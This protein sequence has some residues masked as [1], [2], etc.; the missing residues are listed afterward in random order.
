MQNPDTKSVRTGEI[1][2]VQNAEA[3]DAYTLKLNLKRPD[4]A[5]LATL[6]DRAGMMISPAAV[7][8]FGADLQ[9]NPVGT[10]PFQFVEWVK[11]DHLSSS[12]STGYWDTQ[13]GPYLDGIRYRPIPGRHRQG[14]EPDRRRTR[15]D[16]L[17]HP[18]RRGDA[19]GQS[20]RGRARR[21]VA[22]G[23]RLPVNTTKPPF[24]TKAL[25]LA[26]AHG[27]D[28]D[29][30]TKGVWLGIGVAANGPIAP[31]SWAYDDS[32]K[33]I[34]RDVAKAKQYLA[35]G[36]KP[37]GF[38]F[39]C[40]TNNIPINVQ[41][42]EAMKAMLAEVGIT[43]EVNLVDPARLQ[44]DGNGRAFDMISYQWSGRPDPDGNTY[45]FFKT[46]P[47]SGLNWAGYSNA[48]VDEILDK[49]RE[50]RTRPSARRCTPSW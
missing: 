29:A 3:V 47:G 14:P 45:Q 19:Q 48:R 27:V 24:D 20:E 12:A 41:E 50:V 17:R 28:T 25:R 34:R 13:A 8:K 5:L 23:V 32:V 22:G 9:R 10:G 16:G 2:N 21:P 43:M 39:S 31:S 46:Q 15:R 42:A 49:T 26:V 18:A 11:D 37:N 38:S 6:T 4:A 7:Q 44:A 33:P 35:E 1:A 40:T 36:G 30:I